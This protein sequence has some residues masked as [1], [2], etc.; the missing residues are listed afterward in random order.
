MKAGPYGKKRPRNLSCWQRVRTFGI[1]SLSFV[2]FVAAETFAADGWRNVILT[3]NDERV[4]YRD[5]E[6]VFRDDPG[7]GNLTLLDFA[8]FP[9]E[10]KTIHGVPVTVIGPPTC[11]AIVPGGSLTIVTS[12]MGTRMT[13]GAF[14]HEYDSRVALVDL[15]GDGRIVGLFET[16]LQPSGVSVMPDGETA[17]VANR[18]EGTISVL[19]IEPDGLV[20]IGRVTIAG[21]DDSL[22]HVEISPDG[23][24]A[25][26]TLTEVGAIVVLT[27]S[28][29]GMPH[30]T[31]RL[32]VGGKP[33]AARFLPDGS[34]VFV[35]DIE[36]DCVVQLALHDGS[37]REV[38]EYPVGRIPEGLDVSPDGEWVA[39]S[40]FDG[41]NLTDPTHP[42][43]GEP[44]RIYLLR[45]AGEEFAAAGT[46]EVDG[47]PQFG[48]FAAGSKYLVVSRTGR[49]KLSVF[50]RDGLRFVESGW[51][52]DLNGEPVAA[53]FVK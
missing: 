32:E 50:Q 7:T 40:C 35:A 43:H 46:V 11:V 49:Q 3:A 26:A 21:A 5:N 4:V 15:Q 27:V 37:V 47:A 9:P 14:Q 6:M 16:G 42:K 17:W 45:R 30:V 38:A 13:D 25:V 44:S 51:S 20:E 18:A 53:G 22:S 28:D 39:V 48:V 31:Q 10:V 29:D 52:M 1:A 34:A 2:C 33:Y 41:G 23:N 36:K 24:A 8:S 12:A 19:R